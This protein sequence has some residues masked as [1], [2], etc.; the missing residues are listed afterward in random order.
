MVR[1]VIG[2]ILIGLGFIAWMGITAQS[3]FDEVQ[4]G[5]AGF[6]PGEAFLVSLVYFLPGIALLVLGLR[7]LKKRKTVTIAAL[8]QLKANDRIDVDEILS[9]FSGKFRLDQFKVRKY[10]IWGQ[11]KGL[12]PWK[13]EVV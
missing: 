4:G 1:A 10:I 12:I 11:K 2:A 13:A 7:F 8:D 9:Q 5:P 6:S 3:K